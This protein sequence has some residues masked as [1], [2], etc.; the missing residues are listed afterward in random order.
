MNKRGIALVFA[1]LVVV[2]LSIL[3]S[4]FFVG[5]I[6]ES[7]LVKRFVNSTRAF[8]LAEAGIAEGK[9]DLPGSSSGINY[10]FAYVTTDDLHWAGPQ[11]RYYQIESTG[12]SESITRTLSA[13]VKT[14]YLN[15]NADNFPYAIQT[16]VN[17]VMKGNV[18][19]EPPNEDTNGIPEPGEGWRQNSLLNFANLFTCS[20]E[21]L[22]SHATHLYTSIDASTPMSGITWVEP[23]SG[24]LN[25]AGNYSGSGLMVIQGNAHISG[26]IDFSGIIYVIGDLTIT[27]TVAT[28]GSVLA[29]TDILLDPNTELKGTVD[30]TY[31]LAAIEAALAEVSEVNINPTLVSW[32][33]L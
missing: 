17:L 10:P 33:E 21:D 2:V 16:T 27:G 11:Y 31:D 1:L 3:T 22:K 7:N 6:N 9:H 14:E 23:T 25:I 12:T 28:S 18:G 32:R 19:I 4:S 15:P 24:S 26:T 30:L 13:I 5:S 20:K 8:W 29:E